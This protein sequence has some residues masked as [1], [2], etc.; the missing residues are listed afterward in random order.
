MNKGSD[1]EIL[2]EFLN[3]D[4]ASD[5]SSGSSKVDRVNVLTATGASLM[6][7]N[8]ATIRNYVEDIIPKYSE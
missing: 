5:M 1:S 8:R 4:S 3:P 7:D 6:K 2:K